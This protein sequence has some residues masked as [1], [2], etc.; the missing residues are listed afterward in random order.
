[1]TNYDRVQLFLCETKP[2]RT[3]CQDIGYDIGMERRLRALLAR[4]DNL[5]V[6]IP[7]YE[8]FKAAMK[9]F[10]AKRGEM[11]NQPFSNDEFTLG[12]DGLTY[13]VVQHLDDEPTVLQH[14]NESEKHL[15]YEVDYC[16]LERKP[17]DC[18][19]FEAALNGLE[20][21]ITERA[22]TKEDPELFA[23]SQ[24]ITDIREGIER[25]PT[26]VD[27]EVRNLHIYLMNY[28][29]EIDNDKYNK[30][31]DVVSDLLCVRNEK[32]ASISEEMESVKQSVMTYLESP[33]MHI[34]FLNEWFLGIFLRYE[35]SILS[36]QLP[37]GKEVAWVFGAAAL[38]M[39]FKLWFFG[40]AICGVWLVRLFICL[41][42]KHYAVAIA[43]CLQEFMTS[44]Y[45][46]PE[47]ARR[48]R[49]I[50]QHGYFVQSNTLALL[51]LPLRTLE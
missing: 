4:L 5:T 15:A 30:L 35:N 47:M 41:R 13:K 38:V 28:F 27:T 26:H 42:K 25:T 46:G 29:G 19:D 40:A 50:E 3:L 16:H 6:A 33:W 49:G 39:V 43:Q 22:K 32:P 17:R 24:R 8:G 37:S 48:L 9:A 21:M 18:E 23:R 44:S 12:D 11:A 2:L 45:N 7:D 31:F 51:D 36:P 20:T 34:R 10:M 1:M 14:L